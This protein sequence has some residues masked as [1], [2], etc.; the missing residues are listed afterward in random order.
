MCGLYGWIRNPAHAT[1]AGARTLHQMIRVLMAANESRGDNATGYA[2]LPDGA[3]TP[4]VVKAPLP[5][6]HFLLQHD[7]DLAAVC[8]SRAPWFLGHTRAA[9]I[10]PNDEENAHP[11]LF[12]QTVGAHNG[13]VT[14]HASLPVNKQVY[15][16]PACDS[17]ALIAYADQAGLQTA[18]GAAF[19]SVTLTA[20]RAPFRKVR[21]YTEWKGSLAAAY[22]KPLA[23]LI[24]SSE[25]EHLRLALTLAGV[26]LDKTEAGTHGYLLDWPTET[27]VTFNAATLTP[28][29]CAWQTRPVVRAWAASSW[30]DGQERSRTSST[31]K[32]GYHESRWRKGNYHEGKRRTCDWCKPIT[33]TEG[34]ALTVY[35]GDA[36]QTYAVYCDQARATTERSV[37]TTA[38]PLARCVVCWVTGS[39]TFHA[40]RVL[41][42]CRTCGAWYERVGK[43][44]LATNGR[45]G[46]SD[47]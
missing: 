14:N 4:D 5:A 31:P 46:C 32:R 9:T 30:G 25:V 44:S 11:F 43:G 29:L 23:T 2:F 10:G 27:L 37:T 8:A 16:L 36:Y 19:G 3:Q 18:I 13:S 15:K 42:E 35:R 26:G 34:K 24:W 41:W 21:L 7:A 22:V 20:S 28:A 12:G 39:V 1:P 33:G 17:A 6:S 40:E 45:G 38:D 47:A